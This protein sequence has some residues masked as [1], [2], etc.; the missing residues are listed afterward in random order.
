MK[1][2]KGKGKG[3]FSS[4]ARGRNGKSRFTLIELLVVIAI[5][6]LLAALLFPSLS[7][8][9]AMASRTSCMS[10]VKQISVFFQL[11]ASDFDGFVV[12]ISANNP[13][14]TPYCS[15]PFWTQLLATTYGR[16]Q[17]KVFRCPSTP[18][19][20]TYP[21]TDVRYSS[22]YGFNASFVAQRSDYVRHM[23]YSDILVPSVKCMVAD[24]STNGTDRGRWDAGVY[25]GWAVNVGYFVPGAGATPSGQAA[26]LNGSNIFE[27]EANKIYI[28]DFMKGRHN[29]EC[30][31]M[32]SDM[33][34]ASVSSFDFAWDFYS[35]ENN[36]R[37]NGPLLW[38]YNQ[39]STLTRGTVRP[40]R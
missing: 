11:Y 29:L 33:H 23:R 8:A 20:A 14:C 35:M 2:E 3:L 6:A 31:V 4:A 34:V 13:H 30:V 38:S 37:K 39:T 5:I 16:G 15:H 1:E 28:Q 9:K 12:P 19:R 10:N 22:G 17:Y 27:N 18:V 7:L 40:R 36:A 26:L 25:S 24:F 32:F 21:S